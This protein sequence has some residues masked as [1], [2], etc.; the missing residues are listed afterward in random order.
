MIRINL[1]LAIA[2]LMLSVMPSVYAHTAYYMIGYKLGRQDGK[3]CGY[4]SIE[5]S[6]SMS[7]K[8]CSDY[9]NE[10]SSYS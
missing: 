2:I 5:C 8:S 4:G 3:S 7:N 10:F 6:V 1:I 9:G